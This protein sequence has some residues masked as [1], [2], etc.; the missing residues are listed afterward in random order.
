MTSRGSPARSMWLSA[1]CSQLGAGHHSRLSLSSTYDLGRSPI[2]S[3]I[4]EGVYSLSILNSTNDLESHSSITECKIPLNPTNDLEKVALPSI[5]ECAFPFIST[6][7]LERCTS[8]R[9]SAHSLLNTS[10]SYHEV[11]L[12]PRRG[13]GGG[14]ETQIFLC[15]LIGKDQ[16][17]SPIRVHKY[18]PWSSTRI[19]VLAKTLIP[20]ICKGNH[21][22]VSISYW[23]T[24]LST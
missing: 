7:D 24:A 5:T 18:P 21:T 11:Q 1:A 22:L 4:T 12:L 10:L 6:Y 13:G 15:F 16:S 8:L 17:F 3:W 9:W 2:L 23:P 19:G 14:A 20:Q